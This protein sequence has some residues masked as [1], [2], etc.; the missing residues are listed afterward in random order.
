MIEQI[1]FVGSLAITILNLLFFISLS[2]KS[3]LR[4]PGLVFYKWSEPNN[5]YIFYPA[6]FYQTYWWTQWMF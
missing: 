1:V 4:L 6:F 2:F 3:E 5:F